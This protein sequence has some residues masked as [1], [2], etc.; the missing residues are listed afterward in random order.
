MCKPRV[1]STFH[2]HNLQIQKF[3]AVGFSKIRVWNP[4]AFI[5][6]LKNPQA[7]IGKLKSKA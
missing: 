3:T 5:D 7:F 1:R 4:Q 2:E 6:K